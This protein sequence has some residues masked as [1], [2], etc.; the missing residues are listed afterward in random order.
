[1]RGW[2]S[3]FLLTALAGAEEPAPAI[4]LVPLLDGL[5]YSASPGDD[6]ARLS[7]SETYKTAM[8]EGV[9]LTRPPHP[10]VAFRRNGDRVYYLFYKTTENAFGDRPYVIQRI[11]K[12]ERAWKTPDATPE[13]RVRWQVEVFKTLRGEL[14]NAD[15]HYGSF[16]LQGNHR[17]EIVKE[18]EIGFGEIPGVCEG[19][20]WPFEG[21]LFRMLQPFQEDGGI[22]GKVK[23]REARTWTLTVS[24][25]ATGASSV[26]SPELGFDA[27][28]RLPAREQTLP[29]PDP[30]S[31]RIVL[32]EGKGVEGVAIGESGREA[33]LRVFGGLLEDAPAGR[34]ANLS[35]RGALTVN[36]NAPGKVNTIITRPGFGGRTSRGATH[37]MYRDEVARL[38][39]LP[40][41]SAPDAENWRYEGVQFTFDGFDRV[42]RIVV[43]GR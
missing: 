19:Q 12:V 22:F 21:T 7:E 26:C 34:S 11:R 23:F 28:T 36:L 14:K 31:A 15:E 6:L 32:I 16:G 18:Y 10:I 25:D 38:Y 35:V 24:F 42:K 20:A 9:D 39:G 41:Q 3:L 8:K 43:T 4:R 1:M 2:A 37:G 13:E 27:P 29:P 17:R 33:V 40:P 30:S 5:R